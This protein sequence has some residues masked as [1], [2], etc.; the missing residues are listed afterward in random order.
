MVCMNKLLN[1]ISH[2]KQATLKWSAIAG[3]FSVALRQVPTGVG[4]RDRR[5]ARW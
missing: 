2:S 3:C 1:K 4:D 5:W